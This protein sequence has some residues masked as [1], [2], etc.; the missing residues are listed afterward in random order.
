MSVLDLLIMQNFLGI[1]P[2]AGFFA[3]INR[4]DNSSSAVCQVISMTRAEAFD[5]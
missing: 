2:K 4:I 3:L 5:G 1:V